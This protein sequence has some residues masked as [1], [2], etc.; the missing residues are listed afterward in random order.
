LLGAAKE[1]WTDL[2]AA[3]LALQSVL[4]VAAISVAFVLAILLQRAVARA[5]SRLRLK[6]ERNLL[7][8]ALQAASSLSLPIAWVI[9]CSPRRR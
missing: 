1:I 6:S 4:Q 3:S 8:R 5:I 9:R 2:S 7:R